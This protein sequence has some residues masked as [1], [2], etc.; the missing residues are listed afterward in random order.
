MKKQLLL[1][2]FILVTTI[3]SA[4]AQSEYK[5]AIGVKYYPFGVTYKHFFNEKNAVEAIGYI[6]SDYGFR[7]TGLYSWNW[8]LA[9]VQ[10]LTWYAGPGAHLGFYDGDKKDGFYIGIDGVLGIE[11][12]INQIPVAFSLDWQPS[13]EFGPSDSGFESFGGIGIKYT[14]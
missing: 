13:F 8:Q 14:F 6:W 1:I 3:F 11:Y 12:K 9:N 5:N 7:F 2:C 4:N 10:G